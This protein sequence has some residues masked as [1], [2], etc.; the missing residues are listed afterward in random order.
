MNS[1]IILSGV[2]SE[3]LIESIRQVIKS[4]LSALPRPEKIKTYFSLQEVCEFLDLSKQTVYTLTHKKQIPHIKRAGKL[5]FSR[6][7]ITAWLE[8]SRQ[9]V[10]E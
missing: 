2:T 8:Q 5:L 10:L 7:E 6:S 9:P 3:D 1:Q 4:E